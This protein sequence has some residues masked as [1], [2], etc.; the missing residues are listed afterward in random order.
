[1]KSNKKRKTN[2]IYVTKPALSP[3]K[4]FT[5]ELETVWDSGILTHHG[6]K[7]QKL[8]KGISNLLGLRN[9]TSTSNGT[10]ALQIAIKALELKGEI[11]TSA[12]TWIATVS[13]IKWEKCTPVFCD[14]NPKT[15]NIDPD[16]IIN[17]ISSKTSAIMPVHVFGNPCEIEVIQR[18]ADDHGLKVIYDAAHGVGANYK[19]KSILSYG[20]ISATSLHA[21]KI[22]NSGEGG[23][24]VTSDMGIKSR[25]ERIRFFGH[26]SDSSDIL[27]DGFNGKMTEIHASLGLANLENFWE[28]LKD[29]K[30]KSLLYENFLNGNKN[31]ELQD[32]NRDDSN[33]SYFPIICKDEEHLVRIKKML[34]GNK[35]F[36]RR[37]F[38]PSANNFHHIVNYEPCPI[39]EDIAKRILCLPLYFSLERE[40]IKI[41]CNLIDTLK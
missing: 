33:N 5:K 16:Q 39:S 4:R 17:K 27:E 25:L 9:F 11:I 40:Q 14:I 31:L 38:Y 24:C 35:I 10:I 1:M 28:V 7:V 34:N 23:G 37:Y 41:I 36:P 12:F 6:P 22:L 21:T 32:V 3:L 30:E 18:I 20:D 29:R 26:N 8:E 19:N 2:S 13:A 15:L